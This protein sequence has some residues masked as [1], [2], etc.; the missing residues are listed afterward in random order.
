MM[1]IDRICERSIGGELHHFNAYE[2]EFLSYLLSDNWNNDN[3][4][5]EEKPKMVVS[6]S[7]IESWEFEPECGL[8]DVPTGG[9][10]DSCEHKSS[11]FICSSLESYG[12][13][14]SK[15][16]Y[17]KAAINRWLVKRKRLLESGSSRPYVARS[18]I[19]NKRERNGRGRF[20]KKESGFIPYSY[21]ESPVT[22]RV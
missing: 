17:R 8:L 12:V 22:E 7:V 9:N 16:E 20:M 21:F 3:K 14:P 1:E 15:K 2:E 18:E 4:Y 11:N 6:T 10:E 5:V 13:P 19:A